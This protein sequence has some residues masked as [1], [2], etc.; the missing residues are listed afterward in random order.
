MSNPIFTKQIKGVPAS[1]APFSQDPQLPTKRAGPNSC[2]ILALQL[3]NGGGYAMSSTNSGNTYKKQPWCV[4]LTKD[5]LRGPYIQADS[6]VNGV[7]TP[8]I[9]YTKPAYDTTKMSKESYYDFLNTNFNNFGNV[10]VDGLK[11][12]GPDYNGLPTQ[13]AKMC[14]NNTK[15]SWLD[16]CV[17]FTI[18]AKKGG[19]GAIYGNEYNDNAIVPTCKFYG[20]KNKKSSLFIKKGGSPPFYLHKSVLIHDDSTIINDSQVIFKDAPESKCPNLPKGQKCY[21]NHSVTSNDPIYSTMFA[22]D[23]FGSLYRDIKNDI[24]Y[25][26]PITV[27][28]DYNT[29]DLKLKDFWK[30]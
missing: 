26:D 21:Y 27:A 3:K 14:A 11:Q 30:N 5:Q 13:C 15:N 2:L 25:Y 6:N 19:Y 16:G 18:N 17:G 20:L 9:T 4:P 7:I 10:S 28:N 29:K 23:T 8:W 24:K 1:A 12:I 22:G